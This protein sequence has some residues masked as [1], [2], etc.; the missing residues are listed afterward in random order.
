MIQIASKAPTRWLLAD[1]D[2]PLTTEDM[3]DKTGV[4]STLFDA[5][6]E[7]LLSPE[8]GWLCIVEIGEPLGLPSTSLGANSVENKNDVTDRQTRQTDTSIA[9]SAT[10]TPPVPNFP[11]PII[12]EYPLAGN[13]DKPNLWPLTQSRLAKFKQ[14]YPGVNVLQEC[15]SALGWCVT[16]ETRRKTASG[17]PAFLNGWLTRKQNESQGS[18]STNGHRPTKVVV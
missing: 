4:P 10:P 16:H 14:I 6:I 11:D 12:L 13:H 2:G 18:E 15:R 9:E 5:T 3:A 8:I 17:M 1:D 7:A